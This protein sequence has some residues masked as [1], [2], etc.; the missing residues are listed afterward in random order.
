MTSTDFYVKRGTW[1]NGANS[2]RRENENFQRETNN[3]QFKCIRDQAVPPHMQIDVNEMQ[4][5]QSKPG[6]ASTLCQ[7][8]QRGG[9]AR[10]GPCQKLTSG[11]WQSEY[12]LHLLQEAPPT[13]VPSLPV[14]Q[15]Y[16]LKGRGLPVCD[17]GELHSKSSLTQQGPNPFW[18]HWWVLS[19]DP[20]TLDTLLADPCQQVV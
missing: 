7:A 1:G 18:N 12:S 5:A 9:S 11:A 3:S 13:T 14:L 20:V 10:S 16:T 2:P 17:T 6:F 19:S 15:R 8:S 4:M